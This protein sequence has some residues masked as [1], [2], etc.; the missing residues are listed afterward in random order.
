[1]HPENP[2]E[3]IRIFFDELGQV[4]ETKYSTEDLTRQ[5]ELI[6]D[7]LG[8]PR[9]SFGAL[10]NSYGGSEFERV[11]KATVVVRWVSKYRP[12]FPDIIQGRM[13]RLA[14]LADVFTSDVRMKLLHWA[15]TIRVANEDWALMV[16]YEEQLRQALLERSDQG[17]QRKPGAT[18]FPTPPGST[19]E[20]VIIRFR[21]GHT[22]S[23][24]CRVVSNVYTYTEMGMADGR[25]KTPTIQWQ[26]LR[27]FADGGGKIDWNS[28]GADRKRKK[29][30]QLLARHLMDFFGIDEYPFKQ[31]WKGKKSDSDWKCIGWE[32]KFRIFPEAARDEAVTFPRILRQRPPKI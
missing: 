10:E 3:S 24:R 4:L 17:R 20:H 7:F 23:V 9:A 31:I 5:L 30:V 6:R 13:N 26:L 8:A 22:V 32:A 29:Q 19:W 2:D 14:N 25:N 28:P 1:M 27:V 16:G 21:D 11:E 18:R 15:D 12:M